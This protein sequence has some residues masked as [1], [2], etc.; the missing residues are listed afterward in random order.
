MTDLLWLLDSVSIKYLEAPDTAIWRS[1]NKTVLNWLQKTENCSG[2][3]QF[4]IPTT[5]TKHN[6]TASL[7][8]WLVLTFLVPKSDFCFSFHVLMT[9]TLLGYCL[10]TCSGWGSRVLFFARLIISLIWTKAKAMVTQGAPESIQAGLFGSSWSSWCLVFL[11]GNKGACRTGAG[12]PLG[13]WLCTRSMVAMGT[14]L[15]GTGM[16]SASILSSGRRCR[17]KKHETTGRKILILRIWM[18][19]M[20]QQKHQLKQFFLLI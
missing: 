5:W 17:G 6:I 1:T 10:F 4:N 13:A 19:I 7:P 8:K 2:E 9:K 16:F 11:I 3:S 20:S 18:C 12:L 14:G 15:E